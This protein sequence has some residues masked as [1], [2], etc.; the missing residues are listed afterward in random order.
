MKKINDIKKYFDEINE[1]LLLNHKL[2][3]SL[4]DLILKTKKNNGKVIIFG[5]GGSASTSNHV[6]VDLT[7]NANI[8]AINFNE[9][10]LITCL[11]NDYGYENW[12]K[13]AVEFYLDKERYFNFDFF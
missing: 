3:F 13:K 10:D 9:A 4:K 12:I 5:N 6:S 11:S 1:N 7:K 8:R 2:L